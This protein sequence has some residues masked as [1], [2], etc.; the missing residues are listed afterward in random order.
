MLRA[1]TRG[2]GWPLNFHHNY[3]FTMLTRGLLSNLNLVG[4]CFFNLI[5]MTTITFV[6]FCR[7]INIPLEPIRSLDHISSFCVCRNFICVVE[8]GGTSG[9]VQGVKCKLSCF[10]SFFDSFNSLVIVSMSIP[11]M[12]PFF[13]RSSSMIYPPVSIR[14]ISRF[15]SFKSHQ[16]RIMC[17]W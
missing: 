13:T 3:P 5:S 17:C 4:F 15:E 14:P 8:L 2:H 1:F 16:T 9:G 7:V 6:K 11:V 12:A 10:S